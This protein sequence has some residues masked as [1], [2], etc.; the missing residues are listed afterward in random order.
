M[1]IAGVN[2]NSFVDMK[3]MIAYVVFTAGCNLNCWYCHN[4]HILGD[5]TDNLDMY[6]VI[7]DIR[8][9]ESFIDI[10]VISGGEPTIQKDLKDFI[11]SLKQM[12]IKVKLDT[13]GT[14]PEVIEDLLNNNLLDYIAMDIKAPLCKYPKVAYC[15]TDVNALVESI[16]LI[17]NSGID[18][19]FR[20]TF[21]PELTKVDISEIAKL[22]SG[23]KL[24][25][26][27]QFNP[28]ESMLK[29]TFGPHSREYIIDTVNGL[30]GI[31]KVEVKGLG[32]I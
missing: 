23:A 31:K 29:K 25:V 11:I 20:T 16:F 5:V 4:R 24:Y 17:M 26:I 7:E 30:N 22:I 32:I 19:E 9:R 12:N 21:V 2:V 28:N 1:K 15:E 6:K 18:Y 8:N 3:G 10:V 13:N 27:Q 14:K